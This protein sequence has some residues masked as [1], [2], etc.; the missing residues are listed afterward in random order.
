MILQRFRNKEDLD[1]PQK[2]RLWS[3]N[4]IL[5]MFVSATVML[6]NGMLNP[7]LPIY[8][9]KFGITTDIIGT[10]VSVSLFLTMFGRFTIGGL[11]MKRSKKKLV[12]LSLLFLFVAYICFFFAKN[13][14]IIT[15]AKIVQAVGQGMNITVLSALVIDNLPQSRLG[16][17]LGLYSL[18]G[19]LSATISPMLGTI[20]AKNDQFNL[21]FALSV[22]WT[23]V[24]MF[25]LLWVTDKKVEKKEEPEAAEKKPR[26]RFKIGDYLYPPAFM[27]A[28]ML[29][30]N[31]ITYSA[32]ANFMSIYGLSKGIANVGL[33]F[34]INSIVMIATRPIVGKLTDSKPLAYIIIPGIISATIALAVIAMATN[35]IYIAVAAILFGFG[36]GSCYSAVYVMAI[37][38]ATAETRPIANSTFYVGG[39]IGLSAGSALAG[40][41]AYRIGYENM[42]MSMALISLLSLF[43]FIAYLISKK[44]KIAQV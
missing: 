3:K 10:V 32:I 14:A 11:S 25:I 15:A 19:S 27:P 2:E 18:A 23:A 16:E 40:I 28:I 42:Y 29:L 43:V 37:K 22:A 20:F 8:A 36:F 21:L 41:L 38:S 7:A 35:M 31:G 33:F 24:S 34:T 5:A 12:L 6:G 1:K 9:E 39:D 13:L 26:K 4:Y 17:G 30:F 44:K